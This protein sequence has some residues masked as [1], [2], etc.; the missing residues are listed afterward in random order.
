MSSENTQK[1]KHETLAAAVTADS[2]TGIAQSLSHRLS[3]IGRYVEQLQTHV[4]MHCKLDTPVESC[5]FCTQQRKLEQAI[6]G[7]SKQ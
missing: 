2:G 4:Y 1:A 5:S 6:T 7:G 3:E